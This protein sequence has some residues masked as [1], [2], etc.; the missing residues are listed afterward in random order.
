MSDRNDNLPCM[1]SSERT[2]SAT[3]PMGPGN[4][5]P[6]ASHA[7]LGFRLDVVEGP[8]MGSH[9]ESTTDRSTVGSHASCDLNISDNT[10][11]RFHC[12]IIMDK[13][14][15][16]IRDLGSK[17]GTIVDGLRIVEAFLKNQ[18]TLRLGRSVLRFSYISKH[19][20]RLLSERTSFGRLAGRSVVTRAVFALLERAAA[21]HS[22]VLLEGETGTGKS[23]AARA[24]HEVSA[25]RDGPFLIMDCGTIPMHLLESE[26]FGHEKG[27]FTGAENRRKGIFEEASGGTLFL[28][29]IG[30]LPYEL[31]SKLL[32]VLENK[33][34]RRVGSHV[35][36]PVDVRV[37]AAT[38]RDLR[39]EVNA[40]RFREDLYYRLAV[41]RIQMP[42]LRERLEDLPVLA[43]QLLVSELGLSREQATSLLTSEH[44]DSL[45]RS[46]WPGNIREL[47]SH[48]ERVLFYE[49]W[50]PP[51]LEMIAAEEPL[52]VV[53]VHVPLRE[54][55]KRHMDTFMK[56]YTQELLR[57][58]D[59][60][61]ARAAAAAGVE[62][63]Y[64]YRLIRQFQIKL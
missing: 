44:L 32:G 28:D 40:E 49:D 51:D 30:E 58:H 52:A 25:R 8:G 63:G 31:Q 33:S 34:I 1:E 26:L 9:H 23:A 36:L 59:G 56:A 64:I 39:A 14:H 57:A 50:L 42:P 15:A 21:V 11:S 46:A 24:I 29:E 61:V 13:R 48:L 19:T 2:A 45:Q 53:D 18:S 35:Q 10:V 4:Y 62:P 47:R 5:D 7:V 20:P 12:E 55:R 43:E 3:T 60:H 38:N 27:A 41:I 54:A 37:I 22:T 17:N 6:Q 16:R